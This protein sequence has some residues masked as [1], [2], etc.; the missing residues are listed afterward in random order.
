M[1]FK[2]LVISTSSIYIVPFETILIPTI[3]FMRFNIGESCKITFRFTF[4][5]K[6]IAFHIYLTK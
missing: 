5:R 4:L 1:R 2:K 6:W 3:S